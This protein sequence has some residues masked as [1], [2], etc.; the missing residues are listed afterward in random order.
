MDR[1][2]NQD[3]GSPG[4]RRRVTHRDGEEID[5][6]K[7]GDRGKGCS[8][9]NMLRWIELLSLTRGISSERGTGGAP[10]GDHIRERQQRCRRGRRNW[11]AAAALPV[12]LPLSLALRP[13]QSQAAPQSGHSSTAYREGRPERQRTALQES[14]SWT[15]SRSANRCADRT[16]GGQRLPSLVR[17]FASDLRHDR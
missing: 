8:S 5:A 16:L 3:V 7:P 12:S 10:G 2:P 13:A 11:P 4:A 6:L 15:G 17:R 1:D 14:S 9:W